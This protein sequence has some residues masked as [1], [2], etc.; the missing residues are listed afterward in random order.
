M[1]LPGGPYFPNRK[2]AGLARPDRLAA[3]F[4]ALR[5]LSFTPILR[6]IEMDRALAYTAL[7]W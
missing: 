1:S 2:R 3:L 7:F 5:L 6:Y 4:V